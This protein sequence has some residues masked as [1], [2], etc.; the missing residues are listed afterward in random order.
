[1]RR[2]AAEGAREEGVRASS[3]RR[4][5]GIVAILRTETGWNRTGYVRSNG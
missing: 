5:T 1:M 3:S 4:D 2:R